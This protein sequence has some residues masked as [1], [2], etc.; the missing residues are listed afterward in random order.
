MFTCL[1]Y[2]KQ[3]SLK[4]PLRLG[5][6]SKSAVH[7]HLGQIFSRSR[8][9][10]NNGFNPVV[11]PIERG[12]TQAEMLEKGEIDISFTC[13]LPTILNLR[14]MPH[15]RV[16]SSPGA[17]GYVHLLAPQDIAGEKSL[18][19]F[20][21]NTRIGVRENSVAHRFLI[22]WYSEEGVSFNEYLIE[23]INPVSDD[24]VAALD[25]NKA[26]AVVIWD[27]LASE[28][29]VKENLI[30]IKKEPYY[31]HVVIQGD[32]M[33]K[34]P[35]AASAF[36][37]ALKEALLYAGSNKDE[38][39]KWAEDISGYSE[40]SLHMASDA[41][42]YFSTGFSDVND[43]QV[44]LSKKDIKILQECT[45]FARQRRMIPSLFKIENYLIVD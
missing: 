21:L 36:N 6:S 41:N 40:K 18:K 34:Y 33:E 1:Y 2:I 16:I 25:K 8:I 14:D 5:Y 7:V 26:G 11:I 37:N 19:D 35:E 4:I 22:K 42:I 9:L 29:I 15:L 43:I 23:D 31:S 12:H 24:L 17:L 30:S 3:D 44:S 32:Y 28:L 45:D 20:M 13:D 39:N 38:V 27:P 10:Q